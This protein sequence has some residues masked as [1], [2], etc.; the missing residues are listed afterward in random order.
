MELPQYRIRGLCR[1]LYSPDKLLRIDFR[2]SSL[3]GALREDVTVLVGDSLVIYDREEGR[4]FTGDSS[5]AV[6][7]RGIGERIEPDDIFYALLLAIPACSELEGREIIEFGSRWELRARW[8]DRNIMI[9]GERGKG[10][11]E[12]EQ[13]FAGRGRCYLIRY[14]SYDSVSG[15]VYPGRMRLERN[16]GRE[17]ID[18]ELTDIKEVIPSAS[19]FDPGGS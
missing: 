4:Y 1:I 17:R 14:D 10:P 9:R 8:R 7:R 12:F 2:H 5:L 6:L 16:S 18:F 11:R 19:M 13:C 15:A 3:F